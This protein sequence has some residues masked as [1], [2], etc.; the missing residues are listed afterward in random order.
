M[1]NIFLLLSLLF[2]IGVNAQSATTISPRD[3]E[4]QTDLHKPHFFIYASLGAE[5][6]DHA[7]PI[8]SWIDNQ[9]GANFSG[10]NVFV[11]AT[12]F[13]LD[14]FPHNRMFVGASLLDR[15]LGPVQGG[16]NF[17]F[18]PN[19]H[20]GIRVLRK[21]IIL[22]LLFGFENSGWKFRFSSP[23]PFYQEDA[24]RFLSQK[25]PNGGGPNHY[26]LS[27]SQICLVPALRFA[28]TF[29]DKQVLGIK[30]GY[31]YVYEDG[32]WEFSAVEPGHSDAQNPGLSL[33]TYYSVSTKIPNELQKAVLTNGFFLQMVWGINFTSHQ[34][35]HFDWKEGKRVPN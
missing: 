5:H 29:K 9:Q 2:A 26:E 19:F 23:P 1:K 3:Q 31:R 32:M 30:V 13:T 27:N 11:R 16:P 4:F 6:F 17:G 28:Y 22:D 35:K 7:E 24:N 18:S 14:Y 34:E 10:Y 33:P 8:L 20:F 15:A 21:K 25:Y 12:L